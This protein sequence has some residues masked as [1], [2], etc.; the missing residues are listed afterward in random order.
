MFNHDKQNGG[1]DDFERFVATDCARLRRVLIA[2]FGI[3]IGND[4]ANDAIEYA[5]RNWAR[6]RKMDNPTGY[7]F[8]VGQT[9]ARRH[10]RWERKVELP[11]EHRNQDATI[12]PGLHRA[13]AQISPEQRACVVMVKVF[14]WSYQQTADALGLPVTSV[15]N[16]VHR[17]LTALR[18]A[19][20]VPDSERR[21]T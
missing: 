19:L 6:V 17:G 18:T 13:L 21:P 3:D 5:W 7:L 14:D 15:R 1:A 10:R 4:V 8:R 12:D 2:Y 11:P 16:H 20:S 9:A